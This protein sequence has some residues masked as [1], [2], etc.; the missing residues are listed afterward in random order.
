[1]L[2][3]LEIEMHVSTVVLHPRVR[4]VCSAMDPFGHLVKP[5]DSLLEYYLFFKI[6]FKIPNTKGYRITKENY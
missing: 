1:M 6:D 3:F 2:C 5:R 4:H